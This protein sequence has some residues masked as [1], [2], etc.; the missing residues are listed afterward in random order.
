LQVLLHVL[1]AATC[2][3]IDGLAVLDFRGIGNVIWCL[4]VDMS[5]HPPQAGSTKCEMNEPRQRIHETLI[6]K[7]NTAAI[8]EI[9]VNTLTSAET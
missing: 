1:S 6:I 9:S 3:V 2:F 5:A 7:W 8:W 4:L